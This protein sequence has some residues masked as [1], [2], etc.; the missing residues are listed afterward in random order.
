MEMNTRIQVEHPVTE[1]ITGLDLIKQQILIASGE[2]LGFAQKDIA[3]QGHAIEVRV[4]AEDWE[5]NFRPNPGT[6]ETVY[7]PGGRGVRVDTHIF[8]GYRIPPYY[9]SMIA[10]LIFKGTTR[11]DAM[12]VALRGLEDFM[13]EGITTT[14][15]F[16]KMVISDDRF[17]QGN[18]STH[19]VDDFLETMGRK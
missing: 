9:D 14:V 4:N 16:A 12:A 2:K 17:R 8:A 11:N 7:M 15:P 1:E 3:I 13:L 19:F 6:I 10:K 5:K 18:Y